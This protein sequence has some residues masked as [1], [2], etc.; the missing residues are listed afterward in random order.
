MV[1]FRVRVSGPLQQQTAITQTCVYRQRVNH[2]SFTYLLSTELTQH[3]TARA[4]CFSLYSLSETVTLQ[5]HTKFG[6]HA[7][8]S[9]PAA[10]NSLP[11]DS[12]TVSDS[13]DDFKNKLKTY[14]FKLAFDIHQMSSLIPFYVTVYLIIYSCFMCRSISVIQ[15][16]PIA[17]HL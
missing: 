16:R 12:R 9:G 15:M 14:L 4:S 8:S 1:R 17:I 5:L 7:F 13:T 2:K 11:N 10:W 6:Q 3:T